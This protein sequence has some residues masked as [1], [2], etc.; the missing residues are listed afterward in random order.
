MS[1]VNIFEKL[2]RICFVVLAID[3]LADAKTFANSG[4]KG[5]R[6]VEPRLHQFLLS[7][8]YLTYDAMPK[9]FAWF[10]TVLLFCLG[11]AH[12]AHV[13]RSSGGF[14]SLGFKMPGSVPSSLNGWW[15]DYKSEIGFLGFSYPIFS[16]T[17]PFGANPRASA[18]NSDPI[19]FLGQ[20]AATLQSDFNDMR[21]RFNSRYVH[22]EGACDQDG[23]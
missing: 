15:S 5:R 9:S 4:N 3:W 6:L 17:F 10:T 14:P 11:L 23:F 8:P 2:S 20:N 7:D 12:A 18:W 19:R 22:L 1:P 21:T 13:P 16:C